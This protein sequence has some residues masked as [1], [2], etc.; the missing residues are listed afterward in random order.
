MTDSSTQSGKLPTSNFDV[1]LVRRYNGSGPRYT[2][3]PTALQFTAD[4]NAKQL[5]EVIDLSN[6]QLVPDPLSLYVHIPFCSKLCFYCACNKVIT[7]NKNRAVDYLERLHEEISRYG[8][9]FDDDRELVQLHLGGGT[10]TF[11]ET[12]QIDRLFSHIGDNFRLSK[13]LARDFSIEIDPRTV[14]IE[15]LNRLREIGFTRISLGV[16]DFAPDVQKAIHR[17]QSSDETLALIAHAQAIGFASTNVDLIYGLPLQT[18]VGFEKT[19]NQLLAVRPERLSIFHYAHLPERF[20]PQRKICE[21]QLPRSDEKLNILNGAISQ[22]TQAGYVHVG[23]DHFALVDDSLVSALQDGS[24]QRN[25]Q[26]YSTHARSDL[27]GVGVSAISHI[28][29]SFS[30]NTK[31]LSIYQNHLDEGRMPIDQGLRLSQDDI[32]RK[33]VIEQLMCS[34]EVNLDKALKGFDCDAASY[35]ADELR[36]LRPLEADRLIE[37]TSP[38]VIKVTQ[39]GRFFLRNICMIFDQYLSKKRDLNHYSKVI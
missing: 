22:L 28:G 25:F 23:M 18:A 24:L 17:E 20:K 21:S 26:G 3:Y 30:Q 14:N 13:D 32:L 19:L 4:F 15:T 7:R 33:R 12:N 31:T 36:N 9:I 5:R 27:I 10:P 16:Q 11:L 37:F 34:T 1:D 8:K 35:F 39:K 6:E 2:S 38:N 29:N